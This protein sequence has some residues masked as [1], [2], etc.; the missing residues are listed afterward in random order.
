MVPNQRARREMEAPMSES[1]FH[2]IT[3]SGK[4]VRMTTWAQARAAARR[5]GYFWLDFLEPAKEE[6]SALVEP[7]GLHPLAIEDCTDTNQIPKIDDYRRHT[8]MLFNAYH[9]ADHALS[10]HELDVFIGANFIVTVQQRDAHGRPLLIG[11]EHQAELQRAG[12]RQGPAFL[13][14]VLLDQIVD[15]KFVEIEGLEEEII[16]AE[17]AILGN[18]RRFKPEQLLHLR[19]DLLAVRK[20]LFY[21]REILVKICRKDCPFIGENALYLYRDIY[22]HL[23]K[24]YELTEASRDVVT[25]LMEMYLSMLNNQMA[26]AANET[27]ATVRR[28]TF[29]TTIFMPLSLLAGIGGMSEWTMMTGAA[30]WRIA[31]PLFLAGMVVIGVANYYLLKLLERRRHQER[32]GRSPRT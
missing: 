7:L 16:E 6:L 11:A 23:S 9:Y 10:I 21:E 15:R 24:F 4:L 13:L 26:Q 25:S 1:T 17:E 27:N 28:L 29:I 20:S 31:Y 18:L 19:R 2:H 14:H 32:V 30:N 12:V 22:D 8:F 5:G 3:R